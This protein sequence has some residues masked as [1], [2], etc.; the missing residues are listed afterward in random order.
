[1]RRSGSPPLATAARDAGPASSLPRVPVAEA[2]SES[3]APRIAGP[4]LR[5]DDFQLALYYHR[6]GEFEQA[7]VEYRKVLHGDELNVEAHN[8]LGML[9]HGKG[10]YEDAAREF[11]RVIAIDP[12]YATAHLNLSA[13]YLK[14]GRAEAAATEARRVLALDPRQG[15]AFVNLALAQDAAGQPR[16]AELSLRRALEIDPHDPA[17]NYNLAQAYEKAGEAAL[18][19]ERYRQFLQFAGLEQADYVAAARARLQVLAGGIK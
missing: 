12:S 17:A 4:G 5:P 15:G 11:Q 18:A 14:L 7:L 10:L 3:P 6:T 2:G 8:D 9:Y 1:V 16:D 19:I 13:A